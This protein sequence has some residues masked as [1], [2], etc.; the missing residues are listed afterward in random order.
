MEA[1]WSPFLRKRKAWKERHGEREE[2]KEWENETMEIDK[3]SER[4]IIATTKSTRPQ[5]EQ[6]EGSQEKGKELKRNEKEKRETGE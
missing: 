2:P 6:R 5:E 1:T 4:K 3:T